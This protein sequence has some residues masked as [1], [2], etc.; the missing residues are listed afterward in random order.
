MTDEKLL[1]KGY[2]EFTPG[3]FDNEGVIQCF[4]KRFRDEK[5]IKYFITVN[6]WEPF[7]HPHTGETF[8]SSYEASTQLYRKDAHDAINMLFLSSWDID[9]VEAYLESIFQT[10][11]F[12]YYEMDFDYA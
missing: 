5:G 7:T 10:G 1:S 8:E 6:K 9:D 2:T 4:Q 3:P 11:L 12:D